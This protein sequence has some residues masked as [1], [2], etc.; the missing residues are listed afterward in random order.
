MAKIISPIGDRLGELWVAI[1]CKRLGQV[2]RVV[3]K[4]TM[5][6]VT[7]KDPDGVVVKHGLL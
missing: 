4:T 7:S 5:R 1:S 2:S 6:R 3:C